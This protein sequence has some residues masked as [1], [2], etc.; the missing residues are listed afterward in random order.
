MTDKA[1]TT[2]WMV[3]VLSD[4]IEGRHRRYLV[5][6]GTP[7]EARS[8]VHKM[9]G[10]DAVITSVTRVT[11]QVAAVSNLEVGKVVPA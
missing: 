8:A 1:S 6:L 9:L 10:P 7:D 2:V 4:G 3:E 5:A 11:A